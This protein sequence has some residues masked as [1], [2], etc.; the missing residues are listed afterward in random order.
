VV[1]ILTA[2]V[3]DG[4][5]VGM[6]VCVGGW[7]VGWGGGGREQVAVAAEASLTPLLLALWLKYVL[8]HNIGEGPAVLTRGSC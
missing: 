7:G 2:H 3:R 8:D 6:N 4:L 5:Y 1:F